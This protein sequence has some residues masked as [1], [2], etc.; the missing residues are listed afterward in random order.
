[1]YIY[2]CVCMYVLYVCT[3]VYMCFWVYFHVVLSC[4]CSAY[5]CMYTCISGYM[6]VYRYMYVSM[7]VYKCLCVH[8][9]DMCLCLCILML[10]DQILWVSK[11]WHIFFHILRFEMIMFV[12]F[13]PSHLMVIKS[14]YWKSGN[15]CKGCQCTL[16]RIA[17][18]YGYGCCY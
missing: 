16:K 5:I 15:F 8:V 13:F 6:Y 4:I 10:G 2:E 7:Y 17:A 9:F 14:G 18:Y 1:M 11:K 3:N 12:G